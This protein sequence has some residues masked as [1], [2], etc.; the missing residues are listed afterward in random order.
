MR[1]P[2]KAQSDEAA[3]VNGLYGW[4]SNVKVNLTANLLQSSQL[5]LRLVAGRTSLRPRFGELKRTAV[6]ETV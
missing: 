6:V 1:P 4:Y 5:R 2:A 3:H